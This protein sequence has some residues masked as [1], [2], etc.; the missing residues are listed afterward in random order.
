M[1]KNSEDHFEVCFTDL[2]PSVQQQLLE[3]LGVKS[4]KDMNWDVLPIVHIEK[5]KVST[6]HRYKIG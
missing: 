6:A 2:L 1:C 4:E 5:S 3:F